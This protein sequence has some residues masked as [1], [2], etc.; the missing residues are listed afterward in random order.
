M[1]ASLQQDA[2]ISVERIE[3]RLMPADLSLD[4]ETYELVSQREQLVGRRHITVNSTKDTDLQKKP[5]H[6]HCSASSKDNWRNHFDLS[7]SRQSGF[8]RSENNLD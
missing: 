6:H 3:V 8:F 4:D 1:A 7:I 2:H 5:A